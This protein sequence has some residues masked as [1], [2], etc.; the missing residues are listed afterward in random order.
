MRPYAT[1]PTS[2]VLL[3]CPDKESK[4]PQ[5]IKDGIRD[6]AKKYLTELVTVKK[7]ILRG[8]RGYLPYGYLAS[9]FKLPKHLADLSPHQ[10]VGWREDRLLADVVPYVITSIT[11]GDD[12]SAD[13]MPVDAE[14]ELMIH[15]RC[16]TFVTSAV[17]G[18]S[19]NNTPVFIYATK[20]II[21]VLLDILWCEQQMPGYENVLG[22]VLTDVA[23]SKQ[24]NSVEAQQEKHQYRY[25]SLTLCD[26][27]SCTVVS[28]G[29][30]ATKFKLAWKG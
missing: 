22:Y 21:R 11:M 29:Q 12:K 14:R 30:V 26:P 1:K 19:R 2:I 27:D 15:A 5:K 9:D 7:A 10:S 25:C 18:G 4:L 6:S 17:F 23:E 20:E 24:G 8:V 3:V 13:L 28:R 16:R